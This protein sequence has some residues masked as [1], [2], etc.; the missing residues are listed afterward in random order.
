L[1]DL[2][3]RARGVY[4]TCCKFGFPRPEAE[5]ARLNPVEESLKG[6][7]KIYTLSKSTSVNDYNPFLL[8]L[9]QANIDIQFVSESSLALAN[10]ATGYVT[11]A[12]KS[13]MQEIFSC[14]DDSQIGCL[15]SVFVPFAVE[16]VACMRHLTYCLAIIC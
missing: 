5:E 11:K 2:C 10:Y 15:A 6:R 12:E 4:I 13:H 3:K 16:S 14:T 7:N 9:W 1:V 8:L